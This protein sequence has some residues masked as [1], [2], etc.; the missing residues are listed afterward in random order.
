MDICCSKPVFYI[1]HWS[2]VQCPHTV[3][4]DVMSLLSDKY[5]H[6]YSISAFLTVSVF[7]LWLL[8][9]LI[10]HHSPQEVFKPKGI[11]DQNRI[12]VRHHSICSVLSFASCPGISC[13][14][15]LWQD[16]QATQTSHFD[17]DPPTSW[18]HI[19]I[20]KWQPAQVVCLKTH[21]H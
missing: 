7:H 13:N 2:Q 6:H 12:A 4:Q 1:L 17:K 10:S 15:Y 5:R 11:C 16:Y 19:L 21:K 3:S 8:N 18:Q 9:T 14:H 20:Y